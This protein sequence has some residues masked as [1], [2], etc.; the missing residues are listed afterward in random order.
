MVVSRLVLSTPHEMSY[1]GIRGKIGLLT[2]VGMEPTG[3]LSP[4]REAQV[5]ISGH[6][7][8]A[9]YARLCLWVVCEV[10]GLVE[11]RMG[12]ESAARSNQQVMPDN[13]VIHPGG[14]VFPGE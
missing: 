1:I 5:L 6:I 7:T 14:E 2:V 11:R 13:V 3:F 10:P 4:A 12:I 9:R 8:T